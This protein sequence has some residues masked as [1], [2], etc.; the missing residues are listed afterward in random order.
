MTRP[1]A[2]SASLRLA[3]LVGQ[4][5][6]ASSRW[7]STLAI[8]PDVRLVGILIDSRPARLRIRLRNLRRNL[9]REGVSYLWFRFGRVVNHAV[10]RLAARVVSQ[11]DV[12]A[13]LQRAFPEQPFCLA[14]VAE[15]HGIPVID[16]G[17]LNSASATAALARLR[18]DLGI[19]LGTRLL[20]RST[21][22]VPRLGC[23]NLHLGKVPEYRGMPPGFWEHYDRQRTAGVTV[24]FIDDGL[25][26]GDVLGEDS[27]AI[28]P[29]DSPETLRRKLEI[30]GGEL[31]VR[32]VRDLAR[33][34]ATPRPQPRDGR[35]PRT[36]PTR[37]QDRELRWRL[38]LPAPQRAAWVETLKTVAYLLVYY[39]GLL[40]L[41]RGVRRIVG[42]NCACVLL[43]HRVNDL[44]D[45]PLTTPVRR[46]AEHMLVV[47]THY[48]VMPTS[49]LV[50]KIKTGER[51]PHDAVAIHFD[52]CYQDVS[53]QAAPILACLQMPACCFVSSGYVGT[54]RRFPHDE[55][56]CPW[57]FENLRP[58]DLVAMAKDGF[59]VGSHTVNHVDLGQCPRE[60]ALYEIVQSR[61]ALEAIVGKAVTL[62]S[63]PFGAERNIRPD[64][65]DLIRRSGYEAIFSAYGGY[66]TRRSSV[67][68]LPRVGVSG[69]T[70]P[71][72]LLMEIEGLSLGALKRRWQRTLSRW[73][74]P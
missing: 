42:T 28:D 35:R 12:L 72:D 43:Y 5:S 18:P 46:F 24:H 40:H 31:L 37:R 33:G 32:C 63:Y 23:L 49:V 54:V 51:P 4:D 2:A 68:D 59:E 17:D 34:C 22:A 39:G 38:H 20:K 30:S 74:R 58:E 36:A 16:V 3:I 27:V 67:F 73:R 8:V 7:I 41:V 60:V 61:L 15:L 11:T 52:D 65:V 47:S 57:V 53:T 45:D 50:E 13:L 56:T 25:D 29:L 9:R 14:Q 55:A 6:S 70:R 26:T 64:V 71:L 44:A 66:V 62:F 19:V 21:F 10:E 69:R 48:S 1:D